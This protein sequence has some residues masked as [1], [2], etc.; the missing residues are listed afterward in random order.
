M[1]GICSP[2]YNG[3]GIPC[4]G[5]LLLLKRPI[6]SFC[7]ALVLIHLEVYKR[8]P[9]FCFCF[10]FASLISRS[11][12]R[13]HSA[14]MFG[15]RALVA[16][17]GWTATAVATEVVFVTDL[18]IFTVLAPCAQAAVSG[19]IDYETV[20]HCPSG[21]SALQSCICS[22]NNGGNLESISSAISDSIDYSMRLDGNR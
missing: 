8:C 2:F 17:V 20:S 4:V 22:K 6:H 15:S 12:L 11:P 16:L 7:W 14:N 1:G 13:P 3:D 18:S 5:R 19:V 21:A 10:S 9:L